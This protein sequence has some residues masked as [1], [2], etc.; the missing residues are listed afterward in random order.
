MGNSYFDTSWCANG[1]TFLCVCVRVW[2]S[3]TTDYTTLPTVY[4][5]QVRG[6]FWRS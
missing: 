5:L 1:L 6:H 2:F 3:G 4:F